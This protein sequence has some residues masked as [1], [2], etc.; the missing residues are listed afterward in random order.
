M[1]GPLPRVRELHTHIPRRTTRPRRCE[2]FAGPPKGRAQS[3]GTLSAESDGAAAAGLMSG[4][5][6]SRGMPVTGSRAAKHLGRS[7]LDWLPP[8]L[9]PRQ[10]RDGHDSSAAEIAEW[11]QPVGRHV[12]YAAVAYRPNS[13]P[14]ALG[15]VVAGGATPPWPSAIAASTSRG[16]PSSTRVFRPLQPAEVSAIVALIVEAAAGRSDGRLTL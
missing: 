3:W 5:M 4:F 15:T 9:S 10:R 1:P 6:F 7:A 16:L 13:A 11:P 14:A 8:R 12:F 2:S